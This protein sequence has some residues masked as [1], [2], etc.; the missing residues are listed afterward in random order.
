MNRKKQI[1][2]LFFI[3]T[4]GVISAQEK[5][6]V[7]DSYTAPKILSELTD[8]LNKFCIEATKINNSTVKPQTVQ[9]PVRG[10]VSDFFIKTEKYKNNPYG[11][12]S[13]A[14]QIKNDIVIIK[15]NRFDDRTTIRISE[16]LDELSLIAAKDTIVYEIKYCDIL[17]K[18]EGEKVIVKA[19]W[20]V[21]SHKNSYT[22]EA[23]LTFVYDVEGKPKIELVTMTG[24]KDVENIKKKRVPYLSCSHINFS[25]GW[26]LTNGLNL[27][28][29]IDGISKNWFINHLRFG[30]EYNILFN[31]EGAA[32]YPTS[33]DGTSATMTY[34]TR[35]YDDYGLG[36][37][38]GYRIIPG[39]YDNVSMLGGPGRLFLSMGG[40]IVR[41][42][43][44]WEYQGTSE[45]IEHPRNTAF[46]IKPAVTLEY[47]LSD[48]WGIG[49]EASYY[50]SPQYSQINGVGLNVIIN[51]AF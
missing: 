51:Y 10:F 39:K 27:S 8:K 11:L 21:R 48:F 46:Y 49:V 37:N 12:D 40:G 44:W 22:C 20:T 29:G 30:V 41:Y 47:L 6:Y 36:I 43:R 31:Q 15:G 28:V 16:Y 34:R 24:F 13:I 33:S 17:T 42:G 32:H 2:I 14:P 4:S 26:K 38:I 45:P 18:S 19:Q 7:V 3:L 50:Y 1:L 25:A 9:G 5:E 35:E 23:F